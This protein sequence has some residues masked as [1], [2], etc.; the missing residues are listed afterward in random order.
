MEQNLDKKINNREKII[1]FFRYNKLKIIFVLIFILTVA[2]SFYIF[3]NIQRKKYFDIRE[4][5]TSWI[6]ISK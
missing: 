2:I 1:L 3:S 4:I 5:Y 6:V